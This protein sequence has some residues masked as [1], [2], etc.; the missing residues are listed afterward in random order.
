MLRPMPFDK[1]RKFKVLKWKR[2][3]SAPFFREDTENHVETTDIGTADIVSSQFT[4]A[5]DAHMIVL[6]IDVPA[7]LIPSTTPGNSH[8]FITTCINWETYERLLIALADAGVLEYGYV[9]ASRAR[10]FTA[11]RLPWV[12]K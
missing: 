11:V 12:S 1:L 8:L 10:G 2:D 6:D 3:S 4:T 7:A 9:E 5:Y